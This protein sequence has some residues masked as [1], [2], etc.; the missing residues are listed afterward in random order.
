VWNS[1]KTTP[2]EEQTS[3]ILFC[4]SGGAKSFE[5]SAVPPQ[6]VS[7][8]LFGRETFI[9]PLTG[10]SIPIG[11]TWF[12]TVRTNGSEVS[13]GAVAGISQPGIP[14]LSTHRYSL[15]FLVTAFILLFVADLQTNHL[16]KVKHTKA[17][18]LSRALRFFSG[19]D[20]FI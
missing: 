5:V 15:L 8:T 10:E 18:M 20:R 11:S 9:S 14:S 12:F 16:P 13:S 6:V 4:S 1:K 17:A 19:Q 7:S 3:L 2:P